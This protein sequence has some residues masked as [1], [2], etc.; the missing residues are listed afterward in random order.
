MKKI[1]I[2]FLAF[3]IL[4]VGAVFLLTSGLSDTAYGFFEALKSGNM[5]EADTYLAQNFRATTSQEELQIFLNNT[6]LKDI[7]DVSWGS[8]SFENNSGTIEGTVTTALTGTIPVTLTLIKENSDW[9]ILSINTAAVGVQTASNRPEI[10]SKLEQK[11]LIRESI[12]IFGQSVNDRSMQKLHNHIS[13]LWQKQINVKKLD[14]IFNNFFDANLNFQYL[15]NQKITFDK[16]TIINEDDVM[17]IEGH[18]I[19]KPKQFNFH[20]K[21][22]FEGLKWKL[23]A[24]KI[25]VVDAKK[26]S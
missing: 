24:I 18:Y 6:G 23:V 13:K 15:D 3:I 12:D 10:P 17:I 4:G 7:V 2:G 14:E 22:I 21:Y 8:R 1:F 25:N 19:T 26:S 16:N 20:Q 11:M 5:E 9:K